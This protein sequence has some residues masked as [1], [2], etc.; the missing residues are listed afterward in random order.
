MEATELVVVEFDAAARHAADSHLRSR[1]EHKSL[2]KLGPIDELQ[3]DSVAGL[4]ARGLPPIFT[5]TV[6]LE[7][8]DG[9]VRGA[10]RNDEAILE[11]EGY[12]ET[13]EGA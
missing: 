7:E 3:L 11:G 9:Q 8:V 4:L 6:P 5:V 12:V 10:E 13:D 1:L 2:V